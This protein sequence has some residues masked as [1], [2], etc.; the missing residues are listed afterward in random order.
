LAN[1][2]TV[3]CNWCPGHVKNKAAWPSTVQVIEVTPDKKVV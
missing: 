1:G 3:I 2:N